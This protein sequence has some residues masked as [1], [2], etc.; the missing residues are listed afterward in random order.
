MIR[1]LNLSLACV[2]VS[3]GFADSTMNEA[4]ADKRFGC[5]AVKFGATWCGPCKVLQRQI[6]G[7]KI[8]VDKIPASTLPDTPAGKACKQVAVGPKGLEECRRLTSIDID[9]LPPEQATLLCKKYGVR[10][11]PTTVVFRYEYDTETGEGSEKILRTYPGAGNTVVRQVEALLNSP[12]CQEAKA[13]SGQTDDKVSSGIPVEPSESATVY[14]ESDFVDALDVE[15]P[16]DALYEGD[17]IA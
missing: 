12:L 2:I 10:V 8:C 1:F 11:Y 6:D 14:D 7:S 13:G 16:E 5:Y 3:F 4:H 9:K 15:S 17:D